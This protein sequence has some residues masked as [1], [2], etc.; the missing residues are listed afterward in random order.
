ME[1]TTY[2]LTYREQAN[3]R[4]RV[5][6]GDA[7]TETE[8]LDGVQDSILQENEWVVY[9]TVKATHK[10]D[11]VHSGQIDELVEDPTETQ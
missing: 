8:F 1:D 7:E 9:E 3:E 10:D 2:I 5:L 4:W 11:Y 6:E